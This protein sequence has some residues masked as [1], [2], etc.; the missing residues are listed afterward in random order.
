[1][2]TRNFTED[3]RFVLYTLAADGLE[4]AIGATV[5]KL[6]RAGRRGRLSQNLR[7]LETAGLIEQT[8]A[9]SMDERMFRIT[10]RGRLAVFGGEDPEARWRRPWDGVWRM[11]V[12]DVPQA[13]ASQRARFRRV[14][15]TMHFGWLQNSVWLTPD[16]LGP[17]IQ[18]FERERVTADSLLFM[19]G[20]P[21]GG[22]TDAEIAAAAWDFAALARMH[23][24]YLKIVRLRPSTGRTGKAAAEW[25]KWL[26]TET[27]AWRA[28]AQAD[29]L[30]PEVLWPSGYAGRAV[31]EAHREA[32]TAAGQVFVDAGG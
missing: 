4:R 26:D 29:P 10:A 8:R 23:A 30:L 11:A 17:L 32:L 19:E 21:V 20:R 14:L 31:W 24:S 3:S 18:R 15:R 12:F 25:S 6:R 16:P 1:M 22:E 2:L 5:T 28:I 27:R 7:N 13:Q 9:G